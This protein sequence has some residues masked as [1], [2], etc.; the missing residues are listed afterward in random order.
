MVKFK[1]VLLY[2]RRQI[3][4]KRII[5]PFICK[6]NVGIRINSIIRIVILIKLIYEI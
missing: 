3:L 6:S 2:K 1:F 5:L 4:T